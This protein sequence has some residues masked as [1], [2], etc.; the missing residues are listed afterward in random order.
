[1][2]ESNKK[3]KEKLR[4]YLNRDKLATE[5]DRSVS[6]IELLTVSNDELI[7]V[8][9]IRGVRDGGGANVRETITGIHKTSETEFL[10]DQ[11]LYVKGRLT[12][13]NTWRLHRK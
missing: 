10:I 4:L 13:K 6:D 5:P 2:V 11:L 7:Y 9:K 8:T 12:S 1:M 3:R